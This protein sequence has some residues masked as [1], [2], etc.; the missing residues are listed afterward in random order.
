MNGV[1]LLAVSALGFLLAGCGLQATAGP[2]WA[3]GRKPIA[4]VLGGVLEAH[5]AN[6]PSLG[7]R[8]GMAVDDGLIPRQGIVHL[9]YDLRAVPGRFVLEPRLELG[10][11]RP[12]AGGY[13]GVGAYLGGALSS[14][15]RILGV[16]D[17]ETEFNILGTRIDLVL[18]GRIGAWAP[19]EG[20][21]SA[22]LTREVG[23]DLGL[24]FAITTDV[25]S[26]PQGKIKAPVSSRE[27][28]Q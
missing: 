12:I 11:G 4:I 22:K 16:D 25:P 13:S 21:G 24:R 26:G 9:G 1:A 10:M 27:G 7:A 28:D 23:L 15:L 20:G 19:P 2:S 5:R 3:G 8:V 6:G 17:E 18:G 14:R